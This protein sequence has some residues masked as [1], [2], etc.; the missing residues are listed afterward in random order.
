MADASIAIALK[1]QDQATSGMASTLWSIDS[2]LKAIGKSMSS[3][4]AIGATFF[5]A[6]GAKEVV[7]GLVNIGLQFDRLK[8]SLVSITGTQR[9]A[10]DE[11]KFLQVTA[12]RL[13][14]D[15]LSAASGYKTIA[16]AAQGTVVEGQGARDIFLAMSEAGT[17]LQLTSEELQGALLAV[18]QMLSKG[19]VQAEE[20]RGQLGERL[21]GAFNLAAQAMG[22]TTEGLSKMLEKGEVVASDFL[23]KFAQALHAKYA[24]SASE[25]ADNASASINRL[26][27]AINDLGKTVNES[28]FQGMFKGVVDWFSRQIEQ[29]VADIT[30]M[31]RAWE[32]LKWRRS[33]TGAVDYANTVQPTG[34]DLGMAEIKETQAL[35]RQ[36]Q[37]VDATNKQSAVNAKD[38]ETMQKDSKSALDSSRS[39][40][41]KYNDQLAEYG[42]WLQSGA[43][44]QD[45]FNQLQ[46]KAKEDYNKALESA[47]KS[48]SKIQEWQREHQAILQTG[49]DIAV[50]S[51]TDLE[52]YSV[53]LERLNYYLGY[54]AISSETFTR[55]VEAAWS[56]LVKAESATEG[57]KEFFQLQEEGARIF[58]STR[59]SSEQYATEI[60]RLNYLL[61]YGVISQETY[62]RQVEN[63][64]TKFGATT[65]RMSEF[66]VQAARN[67]QDSL[68]DTLYNVLTG[69]FDD[70]G[71]QFGEMIA[72]MA[73]Q[74][75]AADIGY[76]MFGDF[77]T[78]KKIGG[79]AGD[80]F[81]WIGSFWGGGKAAGGPVYPGRAYVVGERGPE[82]F[83]PGTVGTVI[84]NSA[85]SRPTVVLN[86]QN[87]TG[88]QVESSQDSV[89]YDGEAYHIGI[90][91]KAV[92]NNEGYRNALK[93][94]LTGRG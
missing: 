42:K 31:Q 92:K 29:D 62:N 82:L 63:L 11:M 12:D 67:I 71:T 83:M 68:G 22:T 91:L 30:W 45:Q 2:K 86:I 32:G 14:M 70:I 38:L 56:E 84:P 8:S 60:D 74:A 54:G 10:A 1:F 78:T 24:G 59:T 93:Q 48:A 28:G 21:P 79:W 41:Q 26:K 77:G 15:L 55:S 43:I 81:G 47:A 33:I 50:Q 76:K 9:K 57:W 17:A 27:N 40:L 89:S 73:A 13:G 3:V 64:G 85:M 23:P 87:N 49:G 18:S 75:I 4:S 94:M 66:A 37:L 19:K 7:T 36:R 61:G 65:D 16:A 20:L 46:G 52:K 88:T 90:S 5:S 51:Y 6:W 35:Q 53:E 44:N 58:D 80:L 72:K 25:A 34:P 69:R 39:S